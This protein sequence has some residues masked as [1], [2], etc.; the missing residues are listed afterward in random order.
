MIPCQTSRAEE[1]ISLDHSGCTFE[2]CKRLWVWNESRPHFHV[3]AHHD[4]I[5]RDISRSRCPL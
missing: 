3:L 5:G 1:L 4:A 2:S